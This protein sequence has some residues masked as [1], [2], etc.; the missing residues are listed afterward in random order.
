MV[1]YSN[2]HCI[3]GVTPLIVAC[4]NGHLTTV[5]ELLALGASVSEVSKDGFS[6]LL[7]AAS[8]GTLISQI[9]LK[10]KAFRHS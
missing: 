2:D 1:I 8:N 7:A 4:Y 10:P 6:A 9:R 3:T 5:K